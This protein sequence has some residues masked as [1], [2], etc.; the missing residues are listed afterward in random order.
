MANFDCYVRVYVPL[1]SNGKANT[2]D[3]GYYDLQIDG[4][5]GASLEFDSNTNVKSPVFA[6]GGSSGK[7]YVKIFPASK[8]NTF[9]SGKKLLCKWHF[10]ATSAKVQSFI[11]T[12]QNMLTYQSKSNGIS[13]YKVNSG[14]FTTYNVNRYNPFGATATWCN[15]LGNS[16]L[17]TIY[18]KYTNDSTGYKNY[19]AWEMFNANYTAWRFND[20]V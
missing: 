5:N 12:M 19:A 3:M 9:H 1:D 4:L 16:T 11:S 2:S 17:L 8:T 20:L 14:A 6:F 7:G 18:N 15:M 10:T 13:L